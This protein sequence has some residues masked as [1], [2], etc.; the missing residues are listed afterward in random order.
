LFQWLGHPGEL[1]RNPSYEM[2]PQSE[3]I[4]RNEFWGVQGTF[5]QVAGGQTPQL[6]LTGLGPYSGFKD[7]LKLS[8]ISASVPETPAPVQ[9]DS[10]TYDG[11]VGQYRKTL[12][13]GLIHVGPT[14][15]ISHERD[16]LGDHLI[17]LVRGVPGYDLAEFFPLNQTTFIVNPITTDDQIKFTFIQDGKGRTTGMNVVWNGRKLRGRRISERAIPLSGGRRLG[18]TDWF[19]PG[20]NR[21]SPV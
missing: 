9:L 8:K 3:S 17:G 6:V 7:P 18:L 4:F 20:I 13:F 14:L 11:Y 2:F 10:K 19:H 12:L 5:S 15:S 16:E 1:R 21:P